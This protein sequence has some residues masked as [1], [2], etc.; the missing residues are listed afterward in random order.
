LVSISTGEYK[1]MWSRRLTMLAILSFASAFHAHAEATGENFEPL[2]YASVSVPTPDDEHMLVQLLDEFCAVERLKLLQ[3]RRIVN[4]RAVLD[5]ILQ[6]DQNTFFIA[7]TFAAPGWFELHALSHAPA[8]VWEPIWH[9]LITQ[10][11]TLVGSKRIFLTEAK[12]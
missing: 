2:A 1:K 8:A 4:G 7:T 9:R 5:L 11:T 10:V 3:G 12:S 6:L